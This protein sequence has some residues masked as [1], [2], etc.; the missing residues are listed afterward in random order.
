MVA[1][2]SFT[3]DSLAGDRIVIGSSPHGFHLGVLPAHPPEDDALDVFT[4][5][6]SFSSVTRLLHCLRGGPPLEM[7]GGKFVFSV[8][9]GVP[10]FQFE[11]THRPGSY[12]TAALGRAQASTL[13]SYLEDLLSGS[14]D[15]VYNDSS[16]TPR[17][18]KISRNAACPCGSGRKYKRCCM[19]DDLRVVFPNQLAFAQQ[20]TDPLVTRLL[21][22]AATD[23]TT[24][25]DAEFWNELGVALGSSG[26]HQS[27]IEAFRH[28]VRL[29]PADAAFRVNL[30]VT[31]GLCGNPEQAL[32]T[33]MALPEG[34]PRRAIVIGNLLQD[35]GRAD[36][37]ISW[38]ERA[39]LEEPDF[40][41]AYARL[42]DALDATSSPLLDYWLDRALQSVPRSPAIARF[43]CYYLLRQQRIPELAEADWIDQLQS[44]HGR[45]DIIGR[46]ASDPHLIVE[47]QLFRSIGLVTA[48]RDESELE[49]AVSV[50]T[51]SDL[52]WHLCDPAKLLAAAAANLGR[53]D[54]VRAAYNR[55]CHHCQRERVGIAGPES[56]Y[57][58]LAY[59]RAGN[60]VA[61]ISHAEDSLA[62]D[63]NDLLALRVR[64]WCLDEVG[65]I[66]DAI[67][68]A[69]HLYRLVPTE[70]HLAYNLGYLCGKRGSLGLASH[71][72][73]QA[74]ACE[75]SNWRAVENLAFVA[76]LA[77]EIEGAEGYWSQ[78][79]Q[80][81]I[82]SAREAKEYE[83]AALDEG[84]ETVPLDSFVALKQSKWRTLVECAAQEGP[85]TSRA[86]DLIALNGA[87]VPVIGAHTTV[88]RIELSVQKILDALEQP[89]REE[90]IELRYAL[91]MQQRGDLSPIVGDLKT[92]ILI[93]DQLPAEARNALIEAERQAGTGQTSTDHA[94]QVI[95]FAKAVEITMRRL[96]FDAF[97]ER[98]RT[99]LELE[100]YVQIGLQDKFRQAH[101][102]VRFIERGQHIEL[103]SMT[104]VLKLCR[105]RTGR[106]LLLL[107]RLKNFVTDELRWPELLSDES[108]AD[109][110]AIAD[111]RNPAAHSATYG[112]HDAQEMRSIV[113]RELGRFG[114]DPSVPASAGSS[115]VH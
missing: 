58:A 76:L 40:Y 60:D 65:R 43:Y 52:S 11:L 71:Y 88:G 28:A 3:V 33:V 34:S 38:Y 101:N 106:Q 95:S 68:A 109:L 53:P 93:W 86:L 5:G 51:S 63:S 12:F 73:E 112:I 35:T 79:L 94:P 29:A 39:I 49:K 74:I 4:L 25:Q 110:E 14:S 62:T 92:R 10:T 77:G 19:G 111:R 16:S 17:K 23:R 30:A 41:L 6:L 2:V 82:D 78:Y 75:P 67:A 45:P 50:L 84:V 54:A 55:I 56:T 69:Q 61:A 104:H 22:V 7:D 21:A 89:N 1:K 98:C 90:A 81:F 46:N 70:E 107:G 91:K 24:V 8:V 85:R 87:S 57:L 99:D 115:I 47:A 15:L 20:S 103:G 113:L 26:D 66:D 80:C 97:A 114:V 83:T 44:D 9:S 105:G 102:F 48:L 42:L 64:W 18:P 27:A 31:E 13:E 100:K 96:V 32:E 37:S 72:Y 108:I 36:E 59:G